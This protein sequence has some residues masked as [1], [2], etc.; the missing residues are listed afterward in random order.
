MRTPSSFTTEL[1]LSTQLPA[2]LITAELS[3]RLSLLQ[4]EM[5]GL[6]KAPASYD[7]LP[8]SFETLSQFHELGKCRCVSMPLDPTTVDNERSGDIV[9]TVRSQGQKRQ[10]SSQSG[11]ANP[12][13]PKKR[14]ISQGKPTRNYWLL[15]PDPQSRSSPSQ[16]YRKRLDIWNQE[17]AHQVPGAN[18]SG[19]ATHRRS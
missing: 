6:D 12:A 9:I 4:L 11:E 7:E 19:L 2:S 3:H 5:E 18:L 14:G 16:G 17:P 15:F 1:P 13:K 8:S 10:K